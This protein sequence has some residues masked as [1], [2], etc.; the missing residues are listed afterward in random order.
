MADP[1]WKRTERAIAQ[2]LGG[3]RVPVSGRARGATPDVAHARWSVEVKQRQT[4]PA[5]LETAL[6]QA[7]AAARN[8]QV[9][10]VVLHAAGQAHARD[11]VLLRLADF[12]ALTSDPPSP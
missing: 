7:Q 6:E 10:I 3:R 12:L 11:V 5:W 1:A 9:P 2:R 4:L 8:G